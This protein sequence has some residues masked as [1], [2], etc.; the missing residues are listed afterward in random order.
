MMKLTCYLGGIFT[1]L[2]YYVYV[3][4]QSWK[5]DMHTMNT[6]IKD[7]FNSSDFKMFFNSPWLL[8]AT[9]LI[10]ALTLTKFNQIV[11][12]LHARNT[13][14]NQLTTKC[15]ILEASGMQFM[16][17]FTLWHS[18]KKNISRI[19]IFHSL[20]WH[21]NPRRRTC[22]AMGIF[23][24]KP[25]KMWNSHIRDMFKWKELALCSLVRS[26]ME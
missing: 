14:V 12:N 18:E 9:L 26:A 8:A 3:L 19:Y 17:N 16:R 22:E 6:I 5:Y 11:F 15:N 10:C 13:I 21:I 25:S 24:S 7:R 4:Y 1:I 2:C 20:W 23:R